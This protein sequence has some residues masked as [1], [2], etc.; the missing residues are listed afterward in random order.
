[1][2]KHAA[3]N[4]VAPGFLNDDYY[5]RLCYAML[6]GGL[7]SFGQRTHFGCPNSP[8]VHRPWLMALGLA[9]SHSSYLSLSIVSLY[10]VKHAFQWSPSTVSN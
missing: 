6:P 4:P 8:V 10:T 9:Y 7:S 3:C 5:R 1:M 2:V